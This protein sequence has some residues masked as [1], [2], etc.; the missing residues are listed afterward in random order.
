M[1]ITDYIRIRKDLSEADKKALID[2]QKQIKTTI[3]SNTI[4]KEYITE[5]LNLLHDGLKINKNNCISD[6]FF[7][8]IISTKKLINHKTRIYEE[9]NQLKRFKPNSI[10]EKIHLVNIYRNI[11][12]DLFDPYIS[13]IV[14]CLQFKEGQFISFIYSNLGQGE[15]NKYEYSI[16][17][18][19]PTN[20]FNGYNPIVRN[21]ISHTGT[22]SIKYENNHIIFRSIKRGN[23]PKISY[24]KWTT[25]ELQNKILSLLN[26]IFAIDSAIELF[27]IDI[28]N[29]IKE[30]KQLFEKFLDEI[31]TKN[32]KVEIQKNFEFLVE[33]IKNSVKLNEKQKIEILTNI[34]FIECK[35]REMPI[36]SI[37]FNIK[38]KIVLLELPEKPI[39][40]SDDSEL[41][42]RLT[43]LFR[44]GIIAE[45]CYGN[46]F[47]RI[48]VKEIS[49]KNKEVCKVICNSSDYQ[50]Y[51]KEKIG[52][53]DL[54]Y[55]CEIFILGNKLKIDVDF[56]KLQEL[57]HESIERIFPRKKR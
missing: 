47:N 41:I 32:Q 22:D 48:I 6:I 23:P 12:S 36:D 11:V 10:E 54:L 46:F 26:F 33:K 55:D 20:L 21:A 53:I 35:K 50:K 16:A 9:L 5:I 57:E 51:G 1:N 30:D 29:E 3:P 17:R 31:L 34:L 18:L 13:L 27:G 52:L 39:E 49:S 25:E 40:H 42:G 7:E 44:Y 28:G 2:I 15:R 14:A 56:N 4:A 43:E 19:K 8:F 45:P 38:D 37:K 24:E